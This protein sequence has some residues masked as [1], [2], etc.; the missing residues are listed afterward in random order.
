MAKSLRQILFRPDS[1]TYSNRSPMEM[2][3]LTFQSLAIMLQGLNSPL[4]LCPLR[5]QNEP[6]DDSRS[7]RGYL[8]AYSEGDCPTCSRKL[9]LK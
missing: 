2:L 4:R 7:D 6:S 8:F 1:E 9:R 3:A 5:I